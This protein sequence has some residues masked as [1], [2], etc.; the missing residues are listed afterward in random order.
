MSS[1][2]TLGRHGGVNVAKPRKLRVAVVSPFLDQSHGTE[3]IVIEW[4][5]RLADDFDLHVY[6]QRVEDFD[7]SK[8]TYH[9]IS[10]LPGPH[11]VNYLWWLA[12]NHIR[13]AWDA[14]FRGLK[15]DLIFTPGINCFDADVISVHIVFAEFFRQAKPELRFL[16]NPVTRWPRLLHRRLYYS[17]IIF[18]EGLIYPSPR[19]QLVLIAKKTEVDLKHF[20]PRK[21]SSPIV[22]L[23]L[24]HRRF[25]TLRCAELR[26]TARK[27]LGLEGRD[28]ALLLIGNDLLKKGIA[29]L[30]ES[31]SRLHDI[32]FRLL[33]VSRES[34]AGYEA[35]ISTRCL[36]GRVHFLPPRKDVE[37]YFAAADVYVGPSLED[38]FA[39]PPEE[40]MAC[41]LPVIASLPNGVSEIITHG[42]NG[43]ILEDARDADTLAALIRRVCED[44][45]FRAMLG[46]NA[47]KSVEQFT[48]E[49]NAQ[50]LRA[51]FDEV[52]RQKTDS[53][54][55]GKAL[56][57]DR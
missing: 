18:L 57:P 53:S 40:A 13:R 48:W 56:E 6:S 20:Y 10:E 4:L 5:S 8:F 33:V 19:R 28:V 35:S 55:M 2:N 1:D 31:L 36:N 27:S 32:P 22:Y 34:G 49:R 46:R 16:S 50:D 25:N 3:R 29:A 14:A 17:L 21:R 15:C 24:D 23:G 37:F 26:Q 7:R 54:V 44:E 52:L 38:T 11:I 12:A 30:F 42:E 47:A 43:L 41:G 9:R 39:M 51:I 45:P